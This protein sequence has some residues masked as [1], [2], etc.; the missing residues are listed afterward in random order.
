MNSVREGS[1]A[2]GFVTLLVE[3]NYFDEDRSNPAID[4]IV[5]GFD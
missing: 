2:G 5:N 4:Y 1:C 3:V